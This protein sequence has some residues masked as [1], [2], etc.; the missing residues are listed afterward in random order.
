MKLCVDV[1]LHPS[2]KG[3]QLFL[4]RDFDFL[5]TTQLPDWG[6]AAAATIQD[7][8]SSGRATVALWP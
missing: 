6:G 5:S 4:L 7:G 1:H 2:D 3:E 8:P